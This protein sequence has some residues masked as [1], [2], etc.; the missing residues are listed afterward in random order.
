MLLSL[1]L[2]IVHAPYDFF[3][4]AVQ[5]EIEDVEVRINEGFG[6]GLGWGWDWGYRECFR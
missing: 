3:I 1:M 6:L 4:Q 5:D 2:T